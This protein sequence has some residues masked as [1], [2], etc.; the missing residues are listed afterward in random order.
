VVGEGDG[1]PPITYH[2]L[3]LSYPELDRVLGEMDETFGEELRG[4]VECIGLHGDYEAGL[5]LIREEKLSTLRRPPLSGRH[6]SIGQESE[7]AGLSD[8]ATLSP[9]SSASIVTPEI[10]LKQLDHSPPLSPST[11]EEINISPLP[12][13][14]TDSSCEL[15]P[16]GSNLS[17]IPESASWSPLTEEDPLAS[18]ADPKAIHD[19]MLHAGVSKDAATPEN[20]GRPLHIVFLG[21]SLGNFD[22]PSAGPFLKS[23][24]L[25]AGDTLLLGLDGRPAPGKEGTRK[26]E[27]A[28][29]DPAGYTRAFEE[30]GWEVVRKEL[31]LKD[32]AGVEFVGRY[33][34]V[35]GES[36]LC[37]MP[38]VLRAPWNQ[39]VKESIADGTGRH[40]AYFKSKERQ[41]LRLPQGDITLEKDELLNIEWSYKV[42][43]ELPLGRVYSHSTSS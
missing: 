9:A 12:R 15:T 8:A 4:K 28:Y 19:A 36:H 6:D 14:V 34:E 26:V 35:L 2:P 43:T 24:P 20:T 30:H 22:R 13:P 17:A 18:P 27:I 11:I 3:D 25:R 38:R 10:P 23:L 33:N 5:Q 31:G 41:T 7:N 29:N 37:S 1:H 40:E 39:I 32:D 21:S 16:C 42:G